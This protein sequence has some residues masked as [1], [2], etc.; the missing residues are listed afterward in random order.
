MSKN[1]LFRNGAK[2]NESMFKRLCEYHKCEKIGD[3]KAPKSRE[4]LHDYI[5]L[6]L[7]HIREYNKAWN[8]YE[9][10]NEEEIEEQIRKST[11]WERPSWPL[12]KSSNINWS[13][14]KI[15]VDEIDGFNKNNPN[16]DSFH[17]NKSDLISFKIL[18]MKPCNEIEVIKNAYKKL[19]KRYHPDNN[20][21]NKSYEDKLKLINR[22]YSDLKTSILT[23]SKN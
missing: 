23:L 8:Y 14:I 17:F 4:N 13:N 18:E 19:A 2:N 20:G 21:G 15:Q 11:T 5:W 12:G 6:C 7:D 3:Y 10:M 1:K 9:G 16:I 22:A